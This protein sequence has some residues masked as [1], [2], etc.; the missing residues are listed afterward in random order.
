MRI[1]LITLTPVHI[2]DGNSLKPL[3]Y[4]IDKG[5]VY[6]LDIER[7]LADFSEKERESFLNWMENLLAQIDDIEEKIKSA[8]DNFEFLRRLKKQKREIE[9]RL[10][11]HWFLK[12][13]LETNISSIV[14]K[15]C[16]YR[17][18][19]EVQP[20]QDGFK[21]CLKTPSFNP[22][23][24]GTEIKG[25]LRT[26]FLSFF[27]T[28]DKSFFKEVEIK[29]KEYYQKIHKS[30]LSPQNKRKKLEQIAKELESKILCYGRSDAKYDFFKFI[31]IADTQPLP[32]SYLKIYLTQSLATKCYTKTWLEAISAGV[33]VIATLNIEK[34]SLFL[35]KLGHKKFEK[36]LSL[37][38]LFNICF[39]KAKTLLEHEEKYFRNYPEIFKKIQFLKTQN[40]PDTPLLRLGA[41]QGFLSI[42]VDL[43]LKQDSPQVYKML[44]QAISFIRRWRTKEEFPK[45]RRVITNA[46]GEPKNLLGWVKLEKI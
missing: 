27:L 15:F 41:G 45:T 7:L 20:T 35:E 3:S 32:L 17:I 12:N 28:Q 4:I 18:P 24:P 29:I 21:T 19:F 33:E 44:R 1:K 10:D 6:V 22:Y 43:K 5:W 30:G 34:K 40:R 9:Q 39:Y 14:K 46:M 23:I 25:A 31:S 26:A 11:I 37:D 16:L 2:G 8:G 36:Y 13:R 38:G 42:T